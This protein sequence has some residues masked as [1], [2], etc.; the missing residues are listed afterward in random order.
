VRGAGACRCEAGD[1]GAGEVDA[2]RDPHVGTEPAEVLGVLRR[3]PAEGR[4]AERLLVEGLGEVG[5][6]PDAAGP[7]ELGGVAHQF[8]GDGERRARRDA[9][10]HHGVRRGIVPAVDGGLGLGEDP[11][12]VLDDA[13][14]RQAAGGPAQVHRPARG[15]EP[16]ADLAGRED[17]R[18][19]QVPGAAREDVVVVHGRGAAGQGEPGEVRGRGGVQLVGAE[20]GPD[21]VE[22]GQP[23]EEGVVRGVAAGDPLVE[24]VMGVDE[25]GRDEEPAA[26]D[27]A[28]AVHL[29]RGAAGADRGDPASGEGDV[30]VGVLGVVVVHGR[31]VAAADHDPARIRHG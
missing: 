29:R 31:H 1:G 12:V 10:A 22:R 26:V 15:V 19:E 16:Q 30:A 7:S 18:L 11:V 25:P 3:R 23:A 24:V 20:P 28:P 4:Q 27:P 13:V 5:V 9:D 17:L 14:G 21:R 6:E 8:G 2:V